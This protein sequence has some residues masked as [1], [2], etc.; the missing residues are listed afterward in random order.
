MYCI[1]VPQA[2]EKLHS[3]AKP[4]LSRT[5]RKLRKMPPVSKRWRELARVQSN[6]S[7]VW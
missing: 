7:R 6:I 3:T 2:M 5:L 4:S 1:G